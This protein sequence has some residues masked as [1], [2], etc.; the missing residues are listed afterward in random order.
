MPDIVLKPSADVQI[1]TQESREE[2]YV[3]LIEFIIDKMRLATNQPAFSKDLLS[4]MAL[5]W[6]ESL[7]RHKIR[8][9]DLIRLYQSAL[10]FRAKTD[11]RVAF[12]IEDMLAA[13]FRLK[14]ERA[15]ATKK[16]KSIKDCNKCDSEGFIYFTGKAGNKIQL[17]CNH[18]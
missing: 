13:W 7:S 18:D 11:R 12:N 9:E 16:Y 2:K 15:G 17:A 6:K 10:D 14:E 4:A 3:K 8:G 5:E 1:S